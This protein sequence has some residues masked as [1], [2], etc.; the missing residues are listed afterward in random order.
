MN[1]MSA[2][3]H[4]SDLLSQIVGS[5]RRLERERSIF[6]DRQGVHVCADSNDRPRFPALEQADHSVMRH[7]GSYFQT[8]FSQVIGHQT[9]GLFFAIGE[10]GILMDLVA[11]HLDRKSTRRTPVMWPHRMPSSA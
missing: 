1:V 6:S 2:R 11:D 8:Q 4:D 5:H 9:R 10:L 3:V 7:A